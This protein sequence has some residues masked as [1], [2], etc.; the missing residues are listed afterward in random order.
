MKKFCLIFLTVI[1]ICVNAYANNFVVDCIYFKP[2]DI[3]DH[4]LDKIKRTITEAQ[5]RYEEEMHRHGFGRKT[6]RLQRDATGEIII[7]KV[8][9]LN[10]WRSYT[11]NTWDKLLPELPDRFNPETP[12]WDKQDRVRLIIIG[13]LEY[14]NGVSWGVGWP[15][16]SNRYGGTALIAANSGHF[17]AGLIFHELGHTFGLYHKPP[18][19]DPEAL[20]EYEARWLD[21]HYHFNHR[22]NNFNLP[23]AEW[24]TPKL[25]AIRPDNIKIEIKAAA[26]LGLHQ[27]EIF[28]Q[29][30]ITVVGYDYLN[31]EKTDIISIQAH[32]RAW[33]DKIFLKLMD[34]HGSYIMIDMNIQLPSQNEIPLTNNDLKNPELAGNAQQRQDDNRDTE[35]DAHVNSSFKLTTQWAK[36]KK[37]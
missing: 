28:R 15:R 8:N 21:K 17:S 20:D 11:Q 37:Q 25:T 32:R 30:D 16:H 6:F 22:H 10:G 33:S 35:K 29:E 1:S 4:R 27:A 36:L 9:G 23:T 34:N 24:R 14:T 7:H 12:V 5:I 26:D 31:G 3:G 2:S 19:M 13:G 18:G